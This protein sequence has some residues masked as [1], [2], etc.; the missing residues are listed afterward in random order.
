MKKAFHFFILFSFGIS[1]N[2]QSQIIKVPS[3]NIEA[4][5]SV[6]GG[7]QT[8]FWLLS[9]QYGLL[10]PHKFNS[11]IKA[12]FHSEMDSSKTLD[13][14]YGLDLVNRYSNQYDI[15]LHQA[16][17]RLKW[18]FLRL[19]V[20]S[21]EEKF[22]NQDPEL[23]S[24]GI[25]WSG[26]ARPMPKV[27]ILVPEYTKVPFTKGYL[28]FKAGISHGWFDDNEYIKDFYLHHKYAYLRLG[29]KLPV[30]VHYGFHH[31]AQWGGTT[32]DPTIGKLPSGLSDFF[33]VFLA[34]GGDGSTTTPW[35]EAAN[36]VGNHMG[37]ENFGFDVKLKKYTING[38]WQTIFEDNSGRHHRN[39]EDG[40]WG[41]SI[42]SVNKNKVVNGFVYEF[43]RTTDQSGSTHDPQGGGGNDN[44]FNHGFYLK[45]W[46]SHKMTI[47][48]P[49]ITS[50]VIIHRDVQFRSSGSL[51]N[52]MVKGH[53][54][55][56]SGA[57]R[58]LTYSIM[59]S[60]IMNYGT[61]DS[62][63]YWEQNSFV[64]KTSFRQ[65]L[66]WGLDATINIGVDNSQFYGNNTGIM[67]SLIKTG[68]F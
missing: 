15:Y 37:S 43:I 48:T 36:R 38:Y 39:I 25:M 54:I 47:G 5:T 46:T 55:G 34:K 67:I 66:P 31:F 8:P 58:K 44:Y 33:K 2:I 11:W 42:H 35:E 23:S 17:F 12:G 51:V 3:Y 27:T 18:K 57:Y 53:H 41:L 60:F 19:Q 22:G 20:G 50:P 45:G 26:N 6:A 49:F 32:S 68:K 10:T 9:N 56:L 59:Y 24:G 21:I 28:E 65:V 16:Y 13:Y 14:D 29:G 40:L 62:P 4:G 1:V 63:N 61:K 30:N 64:L 52:N 7:T